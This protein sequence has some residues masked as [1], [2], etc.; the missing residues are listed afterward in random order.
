MS[1]ES[2]RS[3][4]DPLDRP[5]TGLRPPEIRASHLEK[6]AIVYARQS[7][8]LQVREHT[9]STAVQRELVSLPRLWGWP[10]SRIEVID[11]DLGLSGTSTQ[12][13][14]GLHR[15]HD[16]MD[17]GEVGLIVVRDVSR[18]SRNPHDAE[19]FLK[20]LID[21]GILLYA[22]SQLFDGASD[23]L[24][25]L[26]GL[27]VQN[28]LAWWENQN[29]AHIMR[30]ARTA[31]ARQGHAVTQPPAGYVKSSVRGKWIKDPDVGVQEAIRRVFDLYL[32]TGSTGNVVRYM[33]RHNLRL[34]R[35]RG[36]EV[37]WQL[38]SR[39]QIAAIL[40]NPNYT[41]A[42]VFQRTKRVTNARAASGQRMVLRPQA[43]WV[44]APDHH[45]PYVTQAEWQAIQTA[46]ASRRPRVQ[47]PVGRGYALLQG[48]V[49]CSQCKR[50]LTTRYQARTRAD[51]SAS[52]ACMYQ[53]RLDVWH[54]HLS[55]GTR[56]VDAYVVR[57]V[58]DA[59]QPVQVRAALEA[60]KEHGA[61]QAAIAKAQHRHVQ[62]MGDDVEAAR[63]R[64]ALAD[65]D[66]RLVKAD[67]EAQ[68]E[69][70]LAKLDAV[71]REMAAASP[72][73]TIVLRD[74]DARDLTALSERVGAL[75]DAP[76]TAN[77]D[78]KRLLR[79][80]ISCVLVHEVTDEAVELEIIWASGLQERCRVLRSAGVTAR[81]HALALTGKSSA[82]ITAELRAGGVT[83][84]HGRPVSR[85]V[86]ALKLRQRGITAKATRQETFAKIRALLLDERRQREILDVL[87]RDLPHSRRWT[88]K[89][90]SKTVTK[91]RRG[92]IPGVP[93]LP[94]LLPEEHERDEVLQLITQ[95]REA[96]YTYA[97]IARE[98]N[99]SGRRPQLSARF[100]D[101][102]VANLLR[103]PKIQAQKMGN[104]H[105]GPRT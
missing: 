13:R 71:K 91:L 96:G 3:P 82:E 61:E 58:L 45:E 78:R 63:R 27:R 83:T 93:P 57:R 31:K 35:R 53:D 40:A 1:L 56:L 105:E 25:Q 99:A 29:R 23:D 98:L 65:P 24:A 17:R 77:E 34:P 84:T 42:Y 75:W 49:R 52:Y 60:I 22:G 62:Q 15:L 80:V 55:C 69:R 46:L 37:S 102:Q 16:V 33:R 50:W 68:F 51:R 26:F 74:E 54:Y 92:A 6:R 87:N 11:D 2:T 8:A 85:H 47:P 10:E 76:T 59:L 86:V 89:R 64:H 70:A 30:S 21:N 36:A 12:N 67:L 4:H 20:K 81:A 104:K 39:S 97:A 43:D 88:A 72:E 5:A 79:L 94:P 48:L 95:R 44:T 38:P 101:T 90:L 18:I 7:S 103:W 100:S 32:E 19:I 28:L 41:G 9:G 66:H 14:T 73:P